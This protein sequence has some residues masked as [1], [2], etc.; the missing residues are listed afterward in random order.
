MRKILIAALLIAGPRLA[1]AATSSD[2]TLISLGSQVDAF[3]ATEGSAVAAFTTT[4]KVKSE[5]LDG[6]AGFGHYK[7]NVAAPYVAVLDGGIIQD[8]NSDNLGGT[9]GLHANLFQSLGTF[10]TLSPSAQTFWS[11][12]NLT[13]RI[14]YDS[15]NPHHATCSITAGL[16]IPFN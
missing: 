11:H 3:L 6:F 16:A 5:I 10:V 13:P 1:M 4:G 2:P 8:A 14:S 15:D 7:A 12:V 9:F